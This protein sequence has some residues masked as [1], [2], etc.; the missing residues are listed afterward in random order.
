MAPI[1]TAVD[2]I[3]VN[4]AQHLRHGEMKSVRYVRAWLP[5][6][7]WCTCEESLKQAESAYIQRAVLSEPQALSDTCNQQV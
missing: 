2:R 5:V 6:G 1:C 7:T 4:L 3:Y